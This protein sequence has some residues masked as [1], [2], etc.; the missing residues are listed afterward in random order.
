[1]VP[2]F[3]LPLYFNSCMV[4]LRSR[5]GYLSFGYSFV[6]QFLYGAIKVR[7]SFLI[8]LSLALFQ[9]LYGAI[10]VNRCSVFDWFVVIFQFLYGAIKVDPL[11]IRMIERIG[12]SIPV[13]C[14]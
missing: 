1:M 14:D 4:R 13:W 2:V 7:Y 5:T 12:I 11:Y 6:F 8:V 3:L 10:K 9:F